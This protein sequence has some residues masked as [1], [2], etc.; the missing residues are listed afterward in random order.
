M[1]NNIEEEILRGPFDAHYDP[2]TDSYGVWSP[3]Q[4]LAVGLQNVDEAAAM[5]QFLNRNVSAY[6]KGLQPLASTWERA[7]TPAQGASHDSVSF[8]TNTTRKILTW[9]VRI[10]VSLI[11][12]ANIIYIFISSM[13]SAWPLMHDYP[14]FSVIYFICLGLG[15]IPLIGP[16]ALAFGGWMIAMNYAEQVSQTWRMFWRYLYTVPLVL[17][18]TNLAAWCGEA[19]MRGWIDVLG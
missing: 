12:F 19:S 7:A 10:P 8:E 1:P 9:T 6:C 14:V 13:R 16:T 15:L 2:K 5:T 11:S 17:A 4:F 3:E 18:G